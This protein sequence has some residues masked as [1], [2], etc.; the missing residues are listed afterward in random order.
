MKIF[1]N[2]LGLS[3]LS[4]LLVGCSTEEPLPIQESPGEEEAQ[5]E[6]RVGSL[7]AEFS[8]PFDWLGGV[9]KVQAQF[10]DAR[11]VA[12][13]SALEALE[14]WSPRRGLEVGDC[15]LGIGASSAGSEPAYL[16]LLDVGAIGVESSRDRISLSP[17]RLPDL[18]SAFYGVVYG[19][20][21]GWDGEEYHVGYIPGGLYRFAAPGS[22]EA[23]G[24][25]VV[26]QA[27][28]PMELLAVNGEEVRES[29]LALRGDDE[30]ELV[31]EP[32]IGNGAV[33]I[34]LFTGYGPDQSRLQ[35]RAEDSGAFTVPAQLISE[36]AGVDRRLDLEL[37]RVHSTTSDVE[38]LDEATFYFATRDHVEVVL[39]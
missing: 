19:S 23:G 11:G 15:Q 26:L 27:P 3:L 4:V 25:A 20:E 17:R 21:W 39:D 1:Q 5:I 33:Y 9:V 10:L 29:V 16:H 18:M 38:G 24:F 14:V 2:I 31:W 28:E 36:L 35:C 8:G 12:V 37:R 32:G 7:L 6:E 30:L 34:D 22:A 13:E